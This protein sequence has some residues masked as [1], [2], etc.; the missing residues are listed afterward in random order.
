MYN[1]ATQA[2]EAPATDTKARARDAA[3]RKRFIKMLLAPLAFLSFT[4]AVRGAVLRLST[5]DAYRGGLLAAT[6]V[7][8]VMLAL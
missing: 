8:P 6:I 5:A 1:S 3:A 7:G 4:M 2:V